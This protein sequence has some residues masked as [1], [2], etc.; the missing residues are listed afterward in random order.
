MFL[1]QTIQ[2]LIIYRECCEC[3]LSESEYLENFHNV[4]SKEIL[5]LIGNASLH[6]IWYAASWSRHILASR[7]MSAV[8]KYTTKADNAQTNLKNVTQK[9]KIDVT[10]PPPNKTAVWTNIMGNTV[11]NHKWLAITCLWSSLRLWIYVNVTAN[12][13]LKTISFGNSWF[14]WTWQTKHRCSTLMHFR[15]GP[16]VTFNFPNS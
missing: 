3:S 1:E 11:F 9:L 6:C 13:N 16:L 10:L 4:S 7:Q 14:A 8:R 2:H 15:T 12:C 5:A